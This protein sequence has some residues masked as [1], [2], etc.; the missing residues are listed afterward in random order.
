VL[1]KEKELDET[2]KIKIII[3]QQGNNYFNLGKFHLTLEK[4]INR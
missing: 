4:K 3:K 1:G 2:S